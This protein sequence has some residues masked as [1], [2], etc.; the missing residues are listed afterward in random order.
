MSASPRNHL[1]AALSAE[2]LALLAP[3]LRRVHLDQGTVL[4]EAG[5]TLTRAYFPETAIISIVTHLPDGLTIECGIIGCEE[6]LGFVGAACVNIA[7]RQTIVQLSG[8][9]LAIDADALQEAIDESCELLDLMLWHGSV[10]QY[11]S[12]QLIACNA[13]HSVEQRLARWLMQFYDRAAGRRFPLKQEFLAEMLGVRRA[14]VTGAA[15]ALQNQVV[16]SYHRGMLEVRY[17]EQLR[18]ACCPCYE[19]MR[20]A[21]AQLPRRRRTRPVMCEDVAPGSRTH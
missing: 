1:L 9:A 8:E 5:D 16:I 7:L 3:H 13:H 20:A 15:Q 21:P 6:A 14:S 4:Y 2:A 11:R 17:P 10:A 19:I 12:L 18:Q